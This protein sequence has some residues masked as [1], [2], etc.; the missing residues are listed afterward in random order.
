MRNQLKEIFRSSQHEITLLS[1][2]TNPHYLIRKALWR[3]IQKFSLNVSGDVL[4][5]GCGSKPYSRLFSKCDSYVGVDIAIS[6]HNHMV[7]QVDFYYDGK[8]LPFGDCTFDHIISVEVFEHLPNAS[9]ILSE[10]KRV[11]RPGG[12]VFITTPFLYPE[13][14]MPFDFI[15]YTTSGITQLVNNGGF[16]VTSQIKTNQNLGSIIQI[17]SEELFR[18]H[19][20]QIN[21]LA[22]IMCLP[23]II[24]SNLI[25]LMI[26]IIPARNCRAFSNIVT[27][28]TLK[29]NENT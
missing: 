23:L 11:L 21:W 22:N 28:M 5:F 29:W 13:H 16:S 25:V 14:E 27:Q 7:S 1:L 18:F 20:L 4:D 12:T 15:R 6:G 17:F 24:T 9:D 19:K 2:L 26:S 3:Q 10:F 8:T